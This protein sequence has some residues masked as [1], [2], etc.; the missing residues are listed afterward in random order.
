MRISNLT[1]RRMLRRA[2]VGGVAILAATAAAGIAYASIPDAGGV[3][4]GCYQKNAGSLR[5]IDSSTDSCRSSEVALDWNQTGPAGARG[6]TGATGPAGADDAPG[7][8]GAPGDRGPTGPAGAA[9]A[10]GAAGP[11]HAWNGKILGW[12]GAGSDGL[13][14]PLFNLPA[15]NVLV[16]GSLRI[17]DPEALA[18]VTCKLFDPSSQVVDLNGM[19]TTAPP[20]WTQSQTMTLEATERGAAAGVWQLQ[21]SSQYP[22]AQFGLIRF[23][24]IQVGA[25]N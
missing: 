19:T 25:V 11:S 9:G 24:A 8:A 7:P 4:H 10:A 20:D 15:G 14:I 3:V 22:G 6:V 1:R 5:V 17:A 13:T 16:Q 21:C 2:L 18:L 12:F 23:S